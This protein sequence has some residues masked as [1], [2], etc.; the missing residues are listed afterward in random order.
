MRIRNA[1]F[2]VSPELAIGGLWYFFEKVFVRVTWRVVGFRAL[3]TTPLAMGGG[4]VCGTLFEGAVMR[5]GGC[6][7][8][9]KSHG[10]F[11]RIL[12]SLECLHRRPKTH[13][14][15]GER[16]RAPR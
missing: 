5:R 1:I 13:D 14:E 8:K 9:C 3:R 12:S 6:G 15:G 11:G 7:S 4:G 16:T 10:T 2:F